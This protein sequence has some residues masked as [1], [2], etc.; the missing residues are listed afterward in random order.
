MAHHYD[1]RQK[2]AGSQQ[3]NRLTFDAPAPPGYGI[4]LPPVSLSGVIVSTRDRLESVRDLLEE[5]ASR[6]GIQRQRSDRVTAQ[7]VVPSLVQG[8]Q[9]CGSMLAGI[10]LLVEQI[11]KEIG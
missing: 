2:A 11:G 9:E 8:M 7:Q 4:N 5:I 10:E 6:I 1:D 3:Y